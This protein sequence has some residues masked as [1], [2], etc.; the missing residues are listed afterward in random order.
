VNN[1]TDKRAALGINTTSVAWLT[2]STTRTATNQPR[3]IGLD[4]NY[5][6]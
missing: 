3:T 1:L 2:P 5:R 6:F 4:L